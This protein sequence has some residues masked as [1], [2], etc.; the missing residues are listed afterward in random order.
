MIIFFPWFHILQLR[1]FRSLNIQEK[2]NFAKEN[3]KLFKESKSHCD[4]WLT[5]WTSVIQYW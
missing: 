2:Q 1:L 4:L 5:D 3:N